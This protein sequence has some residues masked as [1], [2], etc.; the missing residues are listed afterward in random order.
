MKKIKNIL[1]LLL[2]FF[3]TGCNNF[4]MS[5]EIK[6]DKSVDYKIIIASNSPNTSLE[7]S[8]EEYKN[9]FSAYGYNVSQYN[10]N[11][12]YG[13]VIT[14]HF[15][16]IDDIS[17]GNK[18]DK[19]DLLY[20]YNNSYD[21][22][23]ESRMFSV[24]K[25][26]SSNKYTANFYVDL[27]NLGIDFNNATVKYSVI[28]PVISSDNNSN[29][30]SIDG[31]ELTW[32]ITSPGVTDINYTFE[33]NSYDYIYYGIAIAV[34]IILVIFILGNIGGK[35]QSSTSQKGSITKQIRDANNSGY[36]VEKKIANLTAMSLNNSQKKKTSL[37]TNSSNK[38]AVNM[39]KII[40]EKKK[41]E[42]ENTNKTE[43]KLD[44]RLK[45]NE[46]IFNFEFNN[47]DGNKNKKEQTKEK[48][49][50]LF[51]LDLDSKQEEEITVIEPK[52]KK[53]DDFTNIVN[54]INKNTSTINV[55]SK[56][57][58]INKKDEKTSDDN[59]EMFEFDITDKKEEDN[60]LENNIGNVK[61]IKNDEL[62][63]NKV[64]KNVLNSFDFQE[65][66]PEIND[67]SQGEEEKELNDE[68]FNSELIN[69]NSKS[70][71]VNKKK[72]E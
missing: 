16:N 29:S 37:E 26:L 50:K 24:E 55:N 23:I 2:A 8:I 18:D 13:M 19:F 35:S 41:K 22:A 46:E 44:K 14:K 42:S 3:I 69:V 53:N 33:L 32:N 40:T 62:N 72:K 71:L 52:I 70:V 21:P 61:M 31:T 58:K 12:T 34:V 6:E 45:E 64:D 28:L 67:K 11:G 4:N 49:E 68:D 65:L 27:S 36:D 56:E 60:D 10:E 57:T 30:E 51:N 43:T 48:E 1:M 25:G 63:V 39:D 7:N 9:K 5:M 59:N 47:E 66:E 20:L 54:N 38:N 17:L 15:D